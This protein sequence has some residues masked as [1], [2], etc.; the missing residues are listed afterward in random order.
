MALQLENVWKNYAEK[1]V[2]NVFIILNQELYMDKLQELQNELQRDLNHYEWTHLGR[3]GFMGVRRTKIGRRT[4]DVD[5]DVVI[6]MLRGILDAVLI[7]RSS[8]PPKPLIVT[9]ECKITYA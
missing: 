2:H 6:E 3:S 5:E 1:N 7:T 4:F 8:N 9:G